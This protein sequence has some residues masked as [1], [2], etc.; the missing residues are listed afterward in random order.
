M[1]LYLCIF[2]ED[3]ENELGACDV[4]HYSDFGYFRDTIDRHMKAAAPWFGLT[5]RSL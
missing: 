5:A 2:T 4:G 1:G 3:E